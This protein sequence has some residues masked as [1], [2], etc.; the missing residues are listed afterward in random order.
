MEGILTGTLSGGSQRGN[1]VRGRRAAALRNIEDLLP[2]R[3]TETMVGFVDGFLPRVK[4][5][6]TLVPAEAFEYPKCVAKLGF[7]TPDA[8]ATSGGFGFGWLR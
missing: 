5:N 2:H 4:E 3:V 7:G 1:G 8:E 6:Q